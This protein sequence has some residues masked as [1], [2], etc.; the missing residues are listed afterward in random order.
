MGDDIRGVVID[1]VNYLRREKL[2]G[3]DDPLFPVT[4]V[5]VGGNLLFG[6]VGLDRKH[7]SNAGPIRP[8]FKEA[9]AAAD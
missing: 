6:A 3:L 8:I 2:W 4:K 1:W 9:F 7:W 5:A